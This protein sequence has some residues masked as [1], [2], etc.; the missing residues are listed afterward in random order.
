[1]LNELAVGIVAGL[2]SGLVVSGL[3]YVL[4]GRDLQREAVGLRRLSNLITRGLEDAGIAK[5]NRDDTGEAIGLVVHLSASAKV[6][7]SASA[8]ATVVKPGNTP[9]DT[10]DEEARDE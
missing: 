2:V 8:S 3:F 10:E 6:R 1:M 9:P 7:M 5:F 4:G